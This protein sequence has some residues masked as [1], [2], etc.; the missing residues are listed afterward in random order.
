MDKKLIKQLIAVFLLIA[1]FASFNLYIYFNFTYRYSD[2]SSEVM[3]S[4]SIELDK[5][6]PFDDGSM[7]YKLDSEFKLEGELPVLDGATALFP[8]YS[9]FVNATYPEDSVDFNGVTFNSQSRLQKTGTGPAYEAIVDGSAD[10]IFVAKPSQGQIEYAENKGVELVYEPIGFESFVFIVNSKNPIES[11]TSEQIHRIY[12][13]EYKNWS[14]V[15]G[16]NFPIIAVQRNDGSG[17]QTAMESFMQDTELMK[18]PA[19]IIGKAIGYSFRFYVSDL[20]GKEN[21]KMLSLDGVY[22]NEENIRNGEYP[23]TE[24]FYAVYRAD[25]KNN[26]I[27][28]MIDWILSDEGQSI[29]EETGYVPV[30]K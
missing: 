30:N 15:G 7:I 11:L 28:F 5:Y 19:N 14:D 13:G 6:L 18:G 21:I 23:V 16:D 26:N 17:S 12:S 1:V 24:N 9:A 22:P 10:I 27:A 4:Q 20:S 2:K 3:K 29:I 25:N 8:I